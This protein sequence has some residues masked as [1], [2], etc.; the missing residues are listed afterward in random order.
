MH[1]TLPPNDAA[2]LEKPKESPGSPAGPNARKDI[3]SLTALR[4]FSCF[5][6]LL[7]HSREYFSCWKGVG[8]GFVFA[9]VVPFFF[10]LSGFV[11][12]LNYAHLNSTK[13]TL[14]FYI[15]R[16]ARM[17]PAHALSLLLL[18][19]LIP[20]LFKVT[21]N[22]L[23]LF[24]SNLC[25]VHSWV[26]SRQS[27]F[28]FNAPS[29]SNSTEIF[30]YL[31]FPLL[32]FGFRKRWYLVAGA[33]G[34]MLA[35]MICV[36]QGMHLPEYDPVGLSM[37]GLIYIHPFARLSEFAAGMLTAL[38]YVKLSPRLNF[39]RPVATALEFV[40]LSII[41]IAN[42]TSPALRVA[43]A[44]WLGEAGAYWLQNS[45]IAIPGIAL[46]F[47]ILA[48]EKGW[49]S[50]ALSAPLLVTLGEISFGMYMLHVVL[51]AHR[52]INFPYA[53]SFTDCALFLI[54]LMLSAHLMWTVFESPLRK[55]I[56]KAGNKLLTRFY[57]DKEGDKRPA[58][59]ESK[60]TWSRKRVAIVACEALVLAGL[61]YYTMPGVQPI[62]AA[63][64]EL[65][66]APSSVRD[67][68]FPPH[69]TLKGATASAGKE[70]V[71]VK[72]VWQSQK[73]GLVDFFITL[74]LL[75]AAGDVIGH[76]TYSQDL[77]RTNVDAG[78]TW[79]DSVKVPVRDAAPPASVSVKVLKSKRKA[80]LPT[81][82]ADIKVA[83]ET[84]IVP[85]GQ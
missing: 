30:F 79:C 21:K 5:A 50:K 68:A 47:L 75:D 66:A 67:V 57:P 48:S 20:E 14:S 83:G 69:L 35:A 46:L 62:S 18:V 37:Q 43:T 27:F 7:V 9:H 72:L 15:A 12:T 59:A 61:V 1:T 10:I 60:P 17:W 34:V 85:V 55:A 73:S 22:N 32:L 80:I 8:E 45:G 81:A 33:A 28:S 44:P 56:M 6:F 76:M 54:T 31:C 74:D 25:L 16:F 23:G 4:F 38:V 77:R 53:N 64:A 71:S 52:D 51:L 19:G 82:R 24:L 70:E 84:L 26:P 2:L 29:W 49:L 42:I 11:L 63:Q 58:R 36:C 78:T 65:L 3:K 39:S 13:S 40:I 41:F